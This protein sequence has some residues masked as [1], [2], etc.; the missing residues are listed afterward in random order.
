MVRRN[1][2]SILRNIDES[3]AIH[4]KWAKEERSDAAKEAKKGNH[5]L[6]QV[7]EEMAVND[8]N[9]AEWLTQLKEIKEAYESDYNIQD[10]IEVCV[11][12]WG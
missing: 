3:I 9:E 12:F 1:I 4:K 11:K 7:Y 2:M 8:D 5:F 6:S 10:L